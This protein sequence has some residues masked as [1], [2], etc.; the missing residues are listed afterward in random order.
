LLVK[1]GRDLWHRHRM[2][3]ARTRFMNQLQAV[4][5]IASEF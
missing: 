2:V 5:L 3:Q 1:E 4:A